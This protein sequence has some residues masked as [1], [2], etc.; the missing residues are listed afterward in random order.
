MGLTRFPRGISVYGV[1]VM[2]SAGMRFDGWWGTSRF[3]DYDDGS[4][5]NGGLEPTNAYKHLQTAINASSTNDVIY[6]RNREQD[7]TSTDPEYIIPASTTNWSIAEAKTHLSII[8]ASNVSHIPTEAGKFAVYLRGN[9]TATTGPVLDIQAPFTLVENLAF[10]RGAVTSGGLV[11]LTGNSTSARA[12]ASVVSN[13]LFRMYSQTGAALYNVDN[14]W[15]SVYG[16]DFHDCK[17]GVQMTGSSST[18]RRIRIS[19]CLFR[20]QTAA[21]IDKNIYFAGSGGQDITIDHCDF[22]GEIPTG[23]DNVFIS[24]AAAIQ[25]TIIHCSF[26]ADMVEGTAYITANGFTQVNCHQGLWTADAGSGGLV[27]S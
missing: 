16:C 19:N 8:G 13:C 3:V 27:G 2:P 10:H 11:A 6:I 7:I 12:M 15:I 24:S 21:S 4:D 25:G 14:W 20:N 5:S 23:G 22:V 18:M 17:V 26:P 9:A 1:P